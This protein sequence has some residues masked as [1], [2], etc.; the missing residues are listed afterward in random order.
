MPLLWHAAECADCACVE[1][2]LVAPELDLSLLCWQELE[3]LHELCNDVVDEEQRSQQC[4]EEEEVMARIS[5]KILWHV[6]PPAM[7]GNGRTNLLAKLRVFVHAFGLMSESRSMLSELLRSVVSLHTDYGTEVGL[8]RLKPAPLSEILP[9]MHIPE[10]A[11]FKAAAGDS[12]AFGVGVDFAGEQDFMA[13]IL[14]CTDEQEVFAIPQCDL[15]DLTWCLEGP[16][17]N[18]VI[19]NITDGLGDVMKTYAPFL[20]GLK[21]VCKLLSSKESKQQLLQNVFSSGAGLAFRDSVAA[22]SC[23][24]H[25]KRWGTIAH[26]IQEV[27]KLEAGLRACWSLGKFL[28]GRQVPEPKEDAA[29]EEHGVHL[30]GANE[31]L[32]SEHW[33]ASVK[34]FLHIA[35]A[36]AAA[37]DWVNG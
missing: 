33:W 7:L 8:V 27:H 9:Y 17:L 23:Q 16:D 11:A 26:A 35:D 31:A 29:G 34:I 4:P 25:E 13:N 14:C 37:I 20:V 22:F 2:S 28:Q 36:Q 1:I 21:R 5:S 10:T 6:P 3:K 12:D 19:H 30:P 24:V 18:H 15:C 32:I